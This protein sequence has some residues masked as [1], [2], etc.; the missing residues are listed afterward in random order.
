MGGSIGASLRQVTDA[1]VVV[2]RLVPGWFRKCFFVEVP[3]SQFIDKVFAV[4]VVVQRHIPMDFLTT[5][6][7]V[8][9]PQL[10][11]IDKVIAVLVVVH[12]TVC[13][14]CVSLV[15]GSHLS[16]TAKPEEYRKTGYWFS[17]TCSQIQR[18]VWLDSGYMFIRQ[19]KEA[20]HWLGV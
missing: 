4:P 10:H 1:P 19:R 18:H 16:G 7:T 11:F 12:A 5:Q 8:V 6:K 14:F 17:G 3:Q 20:S 15:S 13:G 9:Y 2:Q